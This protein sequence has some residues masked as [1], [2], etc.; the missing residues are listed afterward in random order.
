MLLRPGASRVTVPRSLQD[1]A[2]PQKESAVRC[3]SMASSWRPKTTN[4]TIGRPAIVV[5]HSLGACVA[6]VLSQINPNVRAVFLE[7]P[8]WFLGRPE[9]WAR[10]IFSKLFSILLI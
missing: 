10:S 1:S 3:T 6:G 8:P 9:E 2:K 7:D 5:G 4:L